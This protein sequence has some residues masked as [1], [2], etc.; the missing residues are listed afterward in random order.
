M[1]ENVENHHDYDNTNCNC[2]CYMRFDIFGILVYTLICV[3]GYTVICFDLCIV[4]Y[5][6]ILV[7]TLTC[8]L[9]GTWVY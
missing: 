1:H 7:C 3:L 2:V 5:L 8:V 4:E 9:K 6:C